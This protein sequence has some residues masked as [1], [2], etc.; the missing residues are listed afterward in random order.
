MHVI[1]RADGDGVEISGM[2]IE[3]RAPVLV[4]GCSGKVPGRFLEVPGVDIA[5]RDDLHLGVARDTAHGIAAH[6]R[7]PDRSDL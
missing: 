5:E 1:R 4:L 2:L 3:Q 7:H 6:A